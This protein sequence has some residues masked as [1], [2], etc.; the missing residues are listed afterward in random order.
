MPSATVEYH[1]LVTIA[2]L[3]MVLISSAAVDGRRMSDDYYAFNQPPT[4]KLYQKQVLA[5]KNLFAISTPHR[6]RP[7]K[8]MQ[9]LQRGSPTNS[10]TVQDHV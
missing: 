5:I 7:Y 10:K 4:I 1:R 6:S 8:R 2:S 3:V 9:R